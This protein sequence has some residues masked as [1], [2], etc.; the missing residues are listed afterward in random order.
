MIITCRFLHAGPEEHRINSPVNHVF[1]GSPMASAYIKTGVDQ[2]PSYEDDMSLVA[3]TSSSRSDTLLSSEN[4]QCSSGYYLDN[5]CGRFFSSKATQSPLPKVTC[6]HLTDKIWT[7]SQRSSTDASL[8]KSLAVVSSPIQTTSSTKIS[9]DKCSHRSVGSLRINPI[10]KH[11][12]SSNDSGKN[13]KYILPPFI[14]ST[15]TSMIPRVSSGRSTSGH[16]VSHVCDSPVITTHPS[17]L[18]DPKLV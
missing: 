15:K 12:S 8:I 11:I 3:D 13:K 1:F 2:Q 5:S 18:Q 14:P 17:T 16:C 9:S 4:S 6:K 10:Q 7:E